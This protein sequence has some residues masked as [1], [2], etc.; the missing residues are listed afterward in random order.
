M[1]WFIHLLLFS[2]PIITLADSIPLRHKIG[3]MIMV[4]FKGTEVHPN[5]TIVRAIR[6]QQIGGIILF[7]NYLPV[8][9]QDCNIKSP[10]QVKRLTQALQSY[11]K[12]SFSGNETALPLLIGVD[13][14]GGRVNRLKEKFEF[15]Q[16]LSAEQ[17]AKLGEQAATPWIQKMAATL[18]NVGINVNF[19]PVVDLKRNSDSPIIAK[20]ERSFS[21]DPQAVI[22]YARLFTKIHQQEG[23]LCAYKHFP[24]H[25]SATGD[26]HE[27]FVDVTN[28]WDKIELAPYKALLNQSNTLVISA[29]VINQ[30]LDKKGYPATLSTAILTG[31][32]REKLGFKGVIVS[33]C[34]QMDAIKKYYGLRE[35]IRM[36][37]QAGID[38]LVFANQLVPVFQ[39]PAEIVDI[40]MEEIKAGRLSENQIEK[41]YQRIKQL[42][43]QINPL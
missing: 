5:D 42:K 10:G 26:T 32:L 36:A 14:E 7:D 2:M 43:K 21:K 22:Q 40:I 28:T 8:K 6:E 27:G 18:K 15:P 33:D 24:G 17:L 34:M 23:I 37:I 29:H 25:G 20:L 4:G 39:D 13:Y 35:A 31:L 12:Q 11:A 3:Q 16:T 19:A 30:N 1:K 9:G 38:I 41:A